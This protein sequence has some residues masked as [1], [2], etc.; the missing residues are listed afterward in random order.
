[1]KS[2]SKDCEKKRG[3]KMIVINHGGK[4]ITLKL[5]MLE[6]AIITEALR[7]YGSKEAKKMVD[8]MMNKQKVL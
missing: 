3:A 5:S 7:K 1:M 6:A 8:T 2:Y 4:S